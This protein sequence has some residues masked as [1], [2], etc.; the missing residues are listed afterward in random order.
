MNCHGVSVIEV[1]RAGTTYAYS[2]TSAYNRRI[3]T[4]TEMTLTARPAD[5]RS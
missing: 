2:K 4:F 1:N 3:T 5:R